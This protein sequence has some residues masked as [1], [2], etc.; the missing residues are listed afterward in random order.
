MHTVQ[1]QESNVVVSSQP[2]GHWKW[3]SEAGAPYS[4]NEKAVFPLGIVI[5]VP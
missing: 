1:I 5:A 4:G 3:E 2:E